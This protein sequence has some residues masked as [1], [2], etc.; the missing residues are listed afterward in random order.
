MIFI[1]LALTQSAI[2]CSLNSTKPSLLH[3]ISADTASKVPHSCQNQGLTSQKEYPRLNRSV[4]I[5]KFVSFNFFLTV[6][7]LSLFSL[8]SLARLA[9][10]EIKVISKF[11]IVRCRWHVDGPT[12]W[13]MRWTH[14]HTPAHTPW[15]PWP[16]CPN[17]APPS[18][19]PRKYCRG[20]SI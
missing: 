7:C 3:D 4:N 18:S 16:P 17:G 13:W 9:L 5:S 19:S 1:M 6:D 15:P 11:F 2:I 10:E 14:W 8:T 12:W 20:G